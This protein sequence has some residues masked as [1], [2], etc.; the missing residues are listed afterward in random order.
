MLSQV[1]NRSIIWR[2]PFCC[3]SGLW[4][5]HPHESS[6]PS[7]QPHINFW[8]QTVSVSLNVLQ[9][10]IFKNKS[11]ARHCVCL[12]FQGLLLSRQCRR[13]DAARALSSW[14]PDRPRYS[15]PRPS[16]QHAEPRRG[17]LRCYHQQPHTSRLYRWQRLCQNLGHQPTRQQ[18]SCVPAGLSG[19]DRRRFTFQ[20][21]SKLLLILCNCL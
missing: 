17:G 1:S 6:R 18:E 8:R 16:D 9:S 13:S 21:T 19:E 14:R 5:S 10:L 2:C 7:S 20:S 3:F 4:S 12:F 15:S 11:D